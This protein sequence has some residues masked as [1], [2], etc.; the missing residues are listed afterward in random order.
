MDFD[1]ARSLRSKNGIREI[2]SSGLLIFH[3]TLLQLAFLPKLPG[4]ANY[5]YKNKILH[6]D[7]GN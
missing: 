7:I 3:L 6:S 1:R 5:L 4:S 2:L